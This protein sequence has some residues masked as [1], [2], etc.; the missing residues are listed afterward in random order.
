MPKCNANSEMR[1]Y[2][3]GDG[4]VAHQIMKFN[5]P[6][7]KSNT[8][9]STNG[10][11]KQRSR[12]PAH[13]NASYVSPK[14][15][16]PSSTPA[17]SARAAG[18]TPMSESTPPT[19]KTQTMD[20]EDARTLGLKLLANSPFMWLMGSLMTPPGSNQTPEGSNNIKMPN[21]VSRMD[22]EEMPNVEM[23]NVVNPT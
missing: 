6:Q 19:S 8:K 15:N 4:A 1:G 21:V 20:P 5:L 23:P 14:P 11:T 22:P 12:H 2:G 7:Q 18:S 17:G 9:F 10:P 3:F 16:G 13:A